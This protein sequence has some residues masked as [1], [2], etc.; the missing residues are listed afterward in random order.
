MEPWRLAICGEWGLT[1]FLALDL[2]KI[3]WFD[4]A[5]PEGDLPICLEPRI[6]L[7]S[8]ALYPYPRDELSRYE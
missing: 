2:T 4:K 5:I 8:W 7:I 6:D 1:F 3:E